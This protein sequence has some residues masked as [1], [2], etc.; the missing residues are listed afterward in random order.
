MA[1]LVL[2]V[3]PAG[4]KRRDDNTS[5]FWIK[6]APFHAALLRRLIT[7]CHVLGVARRKLI[8]WRVE[9]L[10]DS[11]Q[12]K[13]V[14]RYGASF[15]S[16][17]IPV[18]CSFAGCSRIHL[19]DGFD[20]CRMFDVFHHH[21]HL[22]RCCRFDET[23]TWRECLAHYLLPGGRLPEV[24]VRARDAK[25][26]AEAEVRPTLRP[27]VALRVRVAAVSALSLFCCS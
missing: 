8:R 11:A 24:W 12:A 2:C 20:S 10:F 13:L 14:D 3:Q 23:R 19:V 4:M 22:L 27:F 17:G 5:K 9:F 7:V 16:A 15:A 18:R 26:A 25:R 6:C 21:H 1:A